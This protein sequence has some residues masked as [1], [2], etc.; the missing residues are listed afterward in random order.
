M[1]G[2]QGK[3]QHT[4][5]ALNRRAFLQVVGLSG[6]GFMIGCS[7]ADVTGMVASKDAVAEL[8]PFIHI[9]AD[10]TVTVLIKHLDKG[11]GVTTGL[12][13]IVAEELDA[14]WSQMR[15]E[16]APADVSL[17]ANNSLGGTQGT[18]GSTS[19][20]DSWMQLRNAAA[21]ARAMLVQAA[22]AKWGVAANEITVA[23]G[24]IKHAASQNE[25]TFGDMAAGAADQTPP[26][27]PGLKN[28]EDF[29]L[30]GTRL[31]RLDSVEK[32]DGST[33]FTLDIS[34]PG[35]VIAVVEHPPKF[36]ATVK[37][38]D[39]AAA[40]SVPGVHDVVQISRGVA[41]VADSYWS[42]KKGRDALLVEWDFSAAE[43][44]G[45]EQLFA[46]YKAMMADSGLVARESGDAAG[47]LADADK[48]IS[49]EFRFPFRAHATMETMDCVVEIA[50]GACTIRTGA[51]FQTTDQYVAAEIL[52]K[53]FPKCDPDV[54][55]AASHRVVEFGFNLLG[56][57]LHPTGQIQIPIPVEIQE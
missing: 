38:F 44:R 19:V 48:S 57:L 35:M 12:P 22:A 20:T 21:G 32:T 42:A 51:Q 36:G 52:G 8:G 50:P 40:E 30:I 10:N 14:S 53:I 34:L 23:R 7:Q 27:T 45:S 46:D 15:A 4:R 31:P 2:N 1:V 49:R 47:F 11:Q 33:Q 29:T 18:G 56:R 6:A 24:V 39:A 28:P 16:F 5:P 55:R 54:W 9:G 41:V 17:Y 37:S 26:A 3:L 13:T 25:A 43:M